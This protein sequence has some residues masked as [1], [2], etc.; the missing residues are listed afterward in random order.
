VNSHLTGHLSSLQATPSQQGSRQP[1]LLWRT[2]FLTAWCSCFFS[3]KKSDIVNIAERLALCLSMLALLPEEARNSRSV[4]VRALAREA[5]WAAKHLAEQEE[6]QPLP[7]PGFFKA[8]GS[9]DFRRQQEG[10]PW[11][12]H[13]V[14]LAKQGLPLHAQINT[15]LRS[16]GAQLPRGVSERGEAGSPSI[17]DWQNSGSPEPASLFRGVAKSSGQLS[18]AKEEPMGKSGPSLFPG[19]P[20]KNMT[21]N[22]Q[23]S[24]VHHKRQQ[25]PQKRKIAQFGVAR[26]VAPRALYQEVCV[27]SITGLFGACAARA[28]RC[29][30]CRLVLLAGC[31]A[32][33]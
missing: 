3:C 29:S 31:G 23:A 27:S 11:G 4:R 15:P 5:K 33:L 1:L 12:A 30:G 24:R 17:A 28:V 6:P 16:E 7:E 26:K 19:S 21:G 8:C 32:G 22:V 9:S 13:G 18:S 14:N 2:H 20:S 25:T 10:A